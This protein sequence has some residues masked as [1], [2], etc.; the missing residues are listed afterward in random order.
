[1]LSVKFRLPKLA[2]AEGKPYKSQRIWIHGPYF[3]GHMDLEHDFQGRVRNHVHGLPTDLQRWLHCRRARNWP[4]C[5][6]RN[7]CSFDVVF[8]LFANFEGPVLNCI[9]TTKYLRFNTS[10]F[11]MKSTHRSFRI[12]SNVVDVRQ[13]G[14]TCIEKSE[15]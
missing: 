15:T 1:M 7:S 6:V 12:A 4:P 3:W 9:D 10:A 14:S 5:I 2:T 8:E 11:R 13:T